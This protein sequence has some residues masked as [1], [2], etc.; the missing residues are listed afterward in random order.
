MPPAD[1][2][3][4]IAIQHAD[5]EECRALLAVLVPDAHYRVEPPATLVAR[6]SLG[7]LEQ[8]RE[9]LRELD[10]PLNDVLVDLALTCLD[11]RVYER[12]FVPR[13]R[14]QKKWQG[15]SLQI[16][17]WENRD[18]PAQAGPS[19]ALAMPR[20]F[21]KRTLGTMLDEPGR[22]SFPKHRFIF[23]D[24]RG[25]PLASEL[26]LKIWIVPR[27]TGGRLTGEVWVFLGPLV[28][29]ELLAE[30]PMPEDSRTLL[31]TATLSD[32]APVTPGADQRAIMLTP[33]LMR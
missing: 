4:R 16:C 33:H 12:W 9:L 28:N 6:G 20:V 21:E 25:G 32:Q 10:Q 27:M 2:E 26:P 17:I 18:T 13:Q 29:W 1:P 3:L 11:P 31:I 5:A 14:E 19:K 7:A 15:Q 22:V 24:S 30:I 8:V 23:D